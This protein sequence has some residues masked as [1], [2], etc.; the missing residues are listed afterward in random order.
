MTRRQRGS[1]NIKEGEEIGELVMA[2]MIQVLMAGSN[3]LGFYF[4][5]D[6]DQSSES[7]SRATRSDKYIQRITVNAV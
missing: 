1:G 6:V 7:V 4:E 2:Q 5:C 3:G